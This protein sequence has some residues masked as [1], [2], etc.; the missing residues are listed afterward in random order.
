MQRIFDASNHFRHARVFALLLVV[1]NAVGTSYAQPQNTANIVDVTVE[2]RVLSDADIDL[3]QQI[4]AAQE[5]GKW[6]E[7]DRLIAKLGNDVLMGHVLYQ[8]YMHPTKYLSKFEELRDWMAKYADHPDADNIYRLAMKRK[9]AK[10]ASPVA[11]TPRKWK[12]PDQPIT[13]TVS[14]TLSEDEKYQRKVERSLRSEITRHLGRKGSVERAEKQLWASEH[15]GIFDDVTFD[16]HMSRIAARYYYKA[17]YEKSLALA[18]MAADRSGD[19]LPEASWIAGLSAWRAQDWKRAAAYFEKVDP[20]SSDLPE[21]GSAGDY[22][23][24]RA[25]LKDQQ[26]EKVVPL[27]ESAT[28]QHRTFYG[29]LAA[30]QLDRLPQYNWEPPL[31]TSAHMTEALA[32]AGIRRAIALTQIGNRILADQEFRM[33][34]RRAPPDYNEALLNVASHLNLTATQIT[35]ARRA[36]REGRE[37]PDKAL[38][39]VPEHAPE[40][41]FLLDRALLY[42]FMRQESNFMPEAK[43]WVGARGL[44]QLMPATASYIQKDRSLRKGNIN[45]LLVPGFNMTL[46]QK[47][48]LYL[49]DKDTTRGNLILIAAAYNAGPGNVSKWLRNTNHGDDWLLFMESIPVFETRHYVERV[50]ENLWIY[51]ARAGQPSGSLDDLASGLQPRYLPADGRVAEPPGS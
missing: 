21:L 18:T 39:P 7:A 38:F 42:A 46:G 27:L 43:S 1:L 40:N 32:H 44:M 14:V 9:P 28:R 2:A 36:K 24:A 51:R 13:P 16:T 47:Y 4:F 22:W 29:I 49:M 8:R 12:A 26:P 34:V 31:L 35:L 5:P 45:R 33:A 30:R 17:N 37:V 10:A 50:I 41:G 3:Y 6:N 23:A 15:A 19:E 11:P 20:A 25:Y 48:I